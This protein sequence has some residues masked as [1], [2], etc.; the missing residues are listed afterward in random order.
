MYHNL[1][2]LLS[3]NLKLAM[4]MYVYLISMGLAQKKKKNIYIVY[5]DIFKY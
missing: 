1:I 5:T 3:I 4:D 2:K